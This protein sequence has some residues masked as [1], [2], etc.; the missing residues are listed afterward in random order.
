MMYEIL[1]IIFTLVVVG[2]LLWAYVAYISDKGDRL[3]MINS[4]ICPKCKQP[5]IEFKNQKGGGC[6][7]TKEVEY[8]CTNCGYHDSFNIDSGGCGT[9]SCKI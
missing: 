5:T 6:S 4:G 1:N 2:G 8:H 9:G 3:K 7:G